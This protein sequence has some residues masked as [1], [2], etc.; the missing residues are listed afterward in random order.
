[1]YRRLA[2]S[3]IPYE[4]GIFPTARYSLVEAEPVTGRRHQLR[5]HFKHIFHNIIGD[6]QYG[7]RHHTRFF[8]DEFGLDHL[9][10]H[11]WQLSLIH[12]I[13]NTQI[14]LRAPLPGYWQQMAKILGWTALIESLDKEI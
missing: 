13:D 10:L 14:S 8:R 12:P 5:R 4:V 7:D 11:A 1:V 2:I 6:T 3:E 9:F